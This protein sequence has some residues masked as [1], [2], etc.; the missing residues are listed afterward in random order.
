MGKG[1]RDSF[2]AS[3]TPGPG[4]Y[5]NKS[6]NVKNR[7]PSW[8]YA[9]SSRE[10][11]SAEKFNLGPGQ[12]DHPKGYNSV[13]YASP[14]YG[15]DAK[16]AKLKEEINRVPGP[17]SYEHKL[18]QSRKSVR[19]AEKVKDLDGSKVPGPGVASL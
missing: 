10:Y 1:K 8:S 15:F 14:K 2:A 19:I 4:M 16:A 3:M 6:T 7:D 11:A 13:M 18:Q 9:R 17:G 12:Y 5:E